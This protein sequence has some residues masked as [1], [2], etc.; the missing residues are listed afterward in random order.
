MNVNGSV[1]FFL[2]FSFL[3]CLLFYLH[4]GIYTYTSTD[5]YVDGMEGIDSMFSSEASL[6]KKVVRGRDK[7]ADSTKEADVNMCM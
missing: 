4:Q 7:V 2:S 3:F 1:L 6:A 5:G